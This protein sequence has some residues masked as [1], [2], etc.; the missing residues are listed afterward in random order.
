MLWSYKW[1]NGIVNT[2]PTDTDTLVE[3]MFLNTEWKNIC[4]WSF[5]LINFP[6]STSKASGQLI[7]LG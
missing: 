4:H 2:Y 6:F 3:T 7:I 5:S 1:G